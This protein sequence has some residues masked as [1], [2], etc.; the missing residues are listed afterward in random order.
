MRV[1][2]PN[3]NFASSSVESVGFDGVDDEIGGKGG[4]GIESIGGDD[5]TGDFADAAP[6]DLAFCGAPQVVQNVAPF[7]KTAP[8]LMQCEISSVAAGDFA[9]IGLLLDSDSVEVGTVCFVELRGEGI[10]S[11]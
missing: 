10:V 6:L 7:C 2:V 11:S 4:T 3:F 8:H 1:N 9:D 5:G